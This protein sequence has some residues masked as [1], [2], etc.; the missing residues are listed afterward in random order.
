MIL[1]VTNSFNTWL[2]DSSQIILVTILS[3][4]QSAD[5]L[6]WRIQDKFNSML[7]S[8]VS[9]WW[10]QDSWTLYSKASIP[11]NRKWKPLALKAW[12]QNSWHHITHATF[13]NKQPRFKGREFFST[14]SCNDFI[15]LF[16]YF[17]LC[18]PHCCTW[19][20][21]TWRQ[22]GAPLIEV[23]G[24]LILVASLVVEG[25]LQT[26][27]FSGCGTQI[28]CL[29]AWDLPGSRI[30]TVSHIARWIS[31]H[32]TTGFLNTGNSTLCLNGRTNTNSQPCLVYHTLCPG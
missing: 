23:C 22:V 17:W 29:S 18:W 2:G 13:F 3:S 8:T 7:R 24:L 11:G 26:A 28:S 6:I 27:D 5:G 15:Y 1:W 19:P 9:S 4:V 30:Q 10:P 20:F 31:K 32:W 25:G 12:T 21:S 16:I 14:Y